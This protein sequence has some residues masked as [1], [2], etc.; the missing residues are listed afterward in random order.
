MFKIL[1]S[2]LLAPG[3][4]R[5]E[6]EA[7]DIAAKARPGQFIVIRVSDK[8]ERIPLTIAGKDPRRGTITLI[9]Q[10]IGTTTTALFQL[11]AGNSIRDILGPLGC[12]TDIQKAGS[13][14]AIGGGVGVAE[15]LPVAQAYK[16]AGNTV[17]GIMGAR[18]KNLMI[19]EN[20]LRQVCDKLYVTTDDGSA[21]Q[22]GFVSDALQNLLANGSHIDLV[23][24][25]GPVPMMRVIAAITRE[26]GIKTT[27]SLNPIMVDGTGMCGSCR[28]TIG[29]ATHFACVDGPEFDG[30]QV[31]WDELLQRLNLFKQEEKVSLDKFKTECKCPKE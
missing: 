19:L 28:V 27:V 4:K 30:H 18:S 23:Y 9:F 22:K 16:E 14:V 29:G 11:N 17:I 20:E 13:V 8:G 6:V 26:H 31:N 3:V 5:L 21:G 25:I 24:A 10:A 15:V 7:R 12:P 1:S 2:T